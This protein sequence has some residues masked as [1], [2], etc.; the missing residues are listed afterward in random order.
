VV[1][2]KEVKE[3]VDDDNLTEHGILPEEIGAETDPSRG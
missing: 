2:N 3:L 1:G